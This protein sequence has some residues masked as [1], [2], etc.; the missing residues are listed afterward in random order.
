MFLFKLPYRKL[1]VYC[2]MAHIEIIQL[3]NAPGIFMIGVAQLFGY[4]PVN[5]IFLLLQLLSFCAR[6]EPALSFVLALNRLK[7]MC[8]FRIPRWANMAFYIMSYIYGVITTMVLWTPWCGFSFV[9]GKTWGNYDF[10]KPYTWVLER[11]N[12]AFM[13]ICC[14][15]TLSCYVMLFAH[16]IYTKKSTN[17]SHPVTKKETSVLLYGLMRFITDAL[18]IV[19]FHS[20][21][22]NHNYLFNFISSFCYALNLLLVPPLTLLLVNRSFRKDFFARNRLIAT[23][24]VA[25]IMFRINAVTVPQK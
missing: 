23:T 9:V 25:G 8:E 13:M 20:I 1:E 10:S 24:N 3:L 16:M 2:I 4:A 22:L 19:V 17:L 15:A 5:I 12:Y 6:I 14:G 18:I 11:T 21:Q 7:I